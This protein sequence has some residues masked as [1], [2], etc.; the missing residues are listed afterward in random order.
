MRAPLLRP[1]CSTPASRRRPTQARY[2][3]FPARPT[4]ASRLRIATRGRPSR[5]AGHRGTGRERDPAAAGNCGPE[6]PPPRPSLGPSSHRPAHLPLR[7][8]RIPRRTRPT[9]RT[10]APTNIRNSSPFTTTLPI[11]SAIAAMI[12]G[13]TAASRALRSPEPPRNSSMTIHGR[14]SYSM[15]SWTVM[16]PG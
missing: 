9:I 6:R 8:I 15:T 12:S 14:L 13:K 4:P 16:T 3:N 5:R 1:L 10:T 11:P 7:L 2:G